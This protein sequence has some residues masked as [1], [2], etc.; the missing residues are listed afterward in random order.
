MTK[1]TSG[2]NGDLTAAL[3]LQAAGKGKKSSAHVEHYL[4]EQ[5]RLQR[6]HSEREAALYQLRTEN[7]KLR[8]RQLRMQRLH[9]RFRA[10]YQTT[11][12]VI[13]LGLLAVII[14]AVYSAA[15]D[16]SVVVNQFQVPPSFVATGDSGTVVASAFLD[17]LNTL[18]ASARNSQSALALQDAW[19]NN[20]QL[21]VPDV[22]ISLGDIRHSLHQWLGHEIQIN[23]D[24]VE[25]GNQIALTVR[26]SGF[27]AKTFTG[28]PDDLPTLINSAADYVYGEAEPY[29]FATNLE[30]NGQDAQAL[31]LVRAAYPTATAK[32][33]P[34][35][36]NAWG[37]ALG[38]LNQFP[39]AVEK[40][41][42]AIHSEPHFWIAYNNLVGILLV[43]GKEEA[44]FKAGVN[45]ERQTHRGSWFGAHVDTSNYQYVDYLRMDLPAVHAE[46]VADEA[47][48]NGVGTN[49]AP[50][51]PLDAEML[52]RMHADTQ[53]NLILQTTP[54]A[55]TDH[56]VVAATNYVQGL[57]ALDRHDYAQAAN[58]LEAADVL[59]T[60]YP[61]LQG[62]F[63]S[64]PVCYLGLAEE[65]AGYPNK[66]DAA[67]ARGGHFVDCYRFKADIAAH[68]GDWSGA[69]KDYAAAVSLAPSMPQAYQ[70]WGLA[71]LHHHDYIGAIAKFQMAD[72]R[73]PHWCDPL[74]SWGQA[75][76]AEGEYAQAVQKY[77]EAAKYTPGWGALELHWGEAL[78]K[79]GRHS[80]AMA[81]YRSAQTFG[82]LS[83]TQQG[84]LTSL[85]GKPG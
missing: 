26:G 63:Y 5:L 13:A 15:T 4:D 50:D 8:N 67:I 70:S 35:L 24:I 27:A 75:L 78:D 31:A 16:Q 28:T 30:I 69:Q 21:Q 55:G 39:A 19:S 2:A 48:H 9:D 61:V 1:N 49:V 7:I 10:V 72:A 34:W 52:A 43:M 85:L 60:K 17:R 45:F 46:L 37:N 25:H 44:A 71:L 18:Q 22:H 33:K 40:Y 57:L 14:Y 23:G 81:H 65:L 79:L 20:I 42:Q 68:R 82:N 84:Q 73:G 77:A 11:L 56:Y 53:A 58:L 36:L 74:E 54:G 6:Q 59:L 66:A 29:Q 62:D 12:S 76:A 47:A 83:E 38:D 3:A 41:S 80:E 32:E 64:P 51:P